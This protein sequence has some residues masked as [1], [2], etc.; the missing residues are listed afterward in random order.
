MKIPVLFLHGWA[1]NGAIFQDVIDHLGD[2]FDCHAPDLPGHGTNLS[3]T[4]SLDCSAA[5]TKEWVD[6]LDRPILVGWSMGAGV[7]WEYIARFGAADLRGLVTIDM[8]PRMLPDTNWAHG[9]IGQSRDDILST[10]PKIV[11]QWHRMIKSIIANMYADGCDTAEDK[12]LAFLR[13]QDPQHLRPLWDD[14]T[15][16]DARAGIAQ[17]ALPYLVLCGAQ[18]RLYSIN[19]AKWIV[20]QAQNARMEVFPNSGHSPH[21]EEPHSFCK[22]FRHFATTDCAQA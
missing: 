1:M 19:T 18:S 9:M 21:L 10:S 16:M 17:I 8:S 11:P 20:S 14:L 13:A 7:A 6:R 2:G 15:M 4:A 5:L 12:M 3:G 22:T